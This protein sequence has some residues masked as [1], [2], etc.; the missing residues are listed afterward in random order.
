[1]VT[2][3]SI[4]KV[5]NSLLLLFSGETLSYLFAKLIVAKSLLDLFMGA[6]PDLYR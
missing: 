1:M 2:D 4:M 3:K 6:I 5:W